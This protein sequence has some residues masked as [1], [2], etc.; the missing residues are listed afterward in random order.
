MA[1]RRKLITTALEKLT[2]LF[3]AP[4]NSLTD[5]VEA[6]T[7][8]LPAVKTSNPYL[9][10][11][12]SRREVLQKMKRAWD[13]GTVL[14]LVDKGTALSNIIP[15]PTLPTNTYQEAYGNSQVL[16]DALLPSID[17]LKMS[18]RKEFGDD[19]TWDDVMGESQTWVYPPEEVVSELDTLK[20]VLPKR[21]H[22]EA[23][24]LFRDTWDSSHIRGAEA[25]LDYNDHFRRSFKDFPPYETRGAFPSDSLSA[26]QTLELARAFNPDYDELR[27]EAWNHVHDGILENAVPERKLPEWMNLDPKYKMGNE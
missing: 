23:K 20:A 22:K 8:N 27:N 14:S 26:D 4:T 19:A 3:E 17:R 11:P 21:L 2:G 24:K 12:N 15:R 25:S 5:L 1:D 9:E 7:G 6:P 13:A 10:A 16:L 18:L